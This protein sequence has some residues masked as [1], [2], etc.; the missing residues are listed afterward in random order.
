MF[1]VKKHINFTTTQFLAGLLVI[2]SLS[3]CMIQEPK[4]TE[5]QTTSL[6]QMAV[7]MAF[8]DY[9]LSGNADSVWAVQPLVELFDK[10]GELVTTGADAW[11]PITLSLYS[12]SGELTG[13][14]MVYAVRGRAQF[15]GLK[16]NL[17]GN[18]TLKAEKADLSSYGGAEAL[19]VVGD[20]FT[21]S[22]S[23]ANKLNFSGSASVQPGTCNP[24]QLLVQDSGG[25]TVTV[26]SNQGVVFTY[27]GNARVYSDSA[28]SS[29][30]T[31]AT[32]PS[33][34]SGLT[35]YLKTEGHESLKLFA[36]SFSGALNSASLDIKSVTLPITDFFIS[37]TFS[38]KCFLYSSGSAFCTDTNFVSFSN[39]K[40]QKM[41][42][43]YDFK[44]ALLD[45]GSVWC[46]GDGSSGKL[47]NGAGVSSATPV[48]VS[49]L[50]GTATDI[51]SGNHY[52]CALVNISGSGTVK[53]WGYNISRQIGDMTTTTRN[54]ATQVSLGLTGSQSVVSISKS[55]GNIEKSFAVLNDGTVKVWGGGSTTAFNPANLTGVSTAIG[56]TAYLA[57]S[58]YLYCIVNTDKTSSCWGSSNSYGQIGSGNLTTVTSPTS[59]IGLSDIKT[60]ASSLYNSCA[61]KNSGELFC[62]GL[63]DNSSYMINEYGYASS[64][65]KNQVVSTPELISWLPKFSTLKSYFYFDSS[66]SKTNNYFCGVTVSAGTFLCFR[67]NTGSDLPEIISEN[68]SKP[69]QVLVAE[70][71][72]KKIISGACQKITLKLYNNGVAAGLGYNLPIDLA[73]TNG[74]GNFYLDSD[75][76]QSVTQATL[77]SGQTYVDVY[78][79]TDNPSG[80]PKYSYVSLSTNDSSTGTIGLVIQTNGLPFDLGDTPEVIHTSG[81]CFP[82]TLQLV[83]SMGNYTKGTTSS[84][85]INFSISDAS[86]AKIYSDSNCATEINSASIPAGAYSGLV[87]GK[88]IAS[89]GGATV[90]ATAPSITTSIPKTFGF[91]ENC[92]CD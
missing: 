25:N 32:I 28:C 26:S 8:K 21:I 39:K 19:N 45:D 53:C 69:Y 1:L 36:T 15:V 92:G 6:S 88:I 37:P 40:I 60:I 82:Y 35:I 62:W 43:G 85:T 63:K 51:I 18:K 90:T 47:G 61:I 22:S 87:Y 81:I 13:Q 33:G 78:L 5:G 72:S 50:G 86:A 11:A 2:L 58:Y 59:V 29:G 57:G 55:V 9:P 71:N 89:C 3:A 7:R 23:S 54:S 44:C 34:A 80:D 48:Q 56:L 42:L 20:S 27:T 65:S 41:S 12:G 64:T 66:T 14:T 49:N 67:W 17:T 10:N 24:F 77:I 75:C 30:V 31:N 74:F 91:Y 46:W 68:K 52:S 38:T 70:S 76:N 83:D 84:T 73:I 4:I 79:K 16:I